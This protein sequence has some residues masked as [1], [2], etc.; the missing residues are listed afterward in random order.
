[1]ISLEDTEASAEVESL[2][3]QLWDA[4][5]REA[6]LTAEQ[7]GDEGVLFSPEPERANKES[8]SVAAISESQTNLLKLENDRQNEIS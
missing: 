7:R 6:R 1:L 3:G 8:S 5:A 4:V 2:K